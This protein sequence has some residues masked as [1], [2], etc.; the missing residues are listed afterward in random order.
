[1]TRFLLSPLLL[2]IG[3]TRSGPPSDV[4]PALATDPVSADPDDPAIWV[5]P[6][7]P[8][9]S[10]LLGTNKS[11]AP[12]GALVVFGLDGKTR[13]T[14]GGLDRPNNVDVEYGLLL[15]GGPLDIAVVTERYRRRLRVFKITAEG[16]ADITGATAVF[17]GQPGESGEPMGIALYR[18]SRD[19][20]VLAVVSR[21]TGPRDGYLWQYDLQHDGA[22][23]VKAVWV[24]EFGRYSGAGEIEAVAV[25]D[26]LG[27]VYYADE[28]DGIHKYYADPDHPDAA[29]ELAWFG[30]QGYQGDR[31][32][33][34]LYGRPDN[35]GY[36]LSTDQLVGNSRY[37]IYPR[38]GDQSRPLRVFT[39]GADATDG[40][41]ATAAALGPQ[42]PN[43]LFLVM[44]SGP[45]NFLVY[46]WEDIQAL[47]GGSQ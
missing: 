36:L 30:R 10:L 44:N 9:R 23:K 25:D 4:R 28:G 18:R 27:Y 41:D 11:P 13:Q 17:E 16:L 12:R 39:G 5:N 35:T 3:C 33:L 40:A 2:L 8:A 38:D 19:G 32:G 1:M 29:R 14:V 45:K 22:G 7:D 6:A 46:K 37:F 34:A 43:G 42:F 26:A 20:S 47:L 24:R 15:P 21:K 31:E